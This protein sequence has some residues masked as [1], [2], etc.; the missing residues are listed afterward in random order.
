MVGKPPQPLSGTD[1]R[2]VQA[3]NDGDA[4][5][6]LSLWLP[7]TAGCHQSLDSSLLNSVK[8]SP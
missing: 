7:V 1:Y 6:V 5:F 4:S 3:V 2:A 8:F